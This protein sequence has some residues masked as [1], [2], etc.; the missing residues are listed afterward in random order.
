MSRKIQLGANPE[1][2]YQEHK[3]RKKNGSFRKIV[4]PSSELKKAQRKAKHKLEYAFKKQAESFG[5]SECFHGFLKNRNCITAATLHVG[6]DTTVQFDLANFFDTVHKN[7][8]D[9]YL[10]ESLDLDEE[11]LFHK[12]GYAAQGFPSSPIVA[13]IALIPMVREFKE[14]LTQDFGKENFAFTVYADDITISYN[15]PE[16]D[17]HDTIWK[18]IRDTLTDVVESYD[19]E[20]NPKKTRVR[21]AKYGARKILGVNVWE[22]RITATRRV[23]R[24]VRAIRN[25]VD[26]GEP[27]GPVLGGMVNWKNC[28][29]PKN[30]ILTN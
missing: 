7:M 21:F 30:Y 15:N 27:K 3:I 16:K 1:H 18:W 29:F 6:F 2:Y 28:H 14:Y 9:E 8:L 13:N 11:I 26:K 17:K 23:N 10:F 12:K 20:I 4:A 19:F 24:R 22:D 25:Q 5:V